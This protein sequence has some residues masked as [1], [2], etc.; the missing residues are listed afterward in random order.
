MSNYIYHLE[1]GMQVN[2]RLGVFLGRNGSVAA[3]KRAPEHFLPE[4]GDIILYNEN[5]HQL[6]PG[7]GSFG[8]TPRGIGRVLGYGGYNGCQMWVLTYRRPGCNRRE[9]FLSNDFRVGLF[10]YR[11]L[12]DYVYTAD[13]YSYY[14]LDILHPHKDIAELFAD[15]GNYLV[16]EEELVYASAVK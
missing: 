16:P 9:S 2:C 5:T 13:R 14:D 6:E 11:K 12:T 15:D 4:V 8:K 1:E 3:S 7:K 10:V